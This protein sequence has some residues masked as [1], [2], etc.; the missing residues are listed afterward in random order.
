[1]KVTS[2]KVLRRSTFL[3]AFVPARFTPC[4]PPLFP[5]VLSYHIVRYARYSEAALQVEV[6]TLNG[7]LPCAHSAATMLA[8]SRLS[9][10]LPLIITAE[11]RRPVARSNMIITRVRSP[12]HV[13]FHDFV[14]LDHWRI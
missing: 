9:A 7:L 5:C 11:R 14:I 12:D 3:A 2:L 6:A 1:M 13:Q 10:C 8:V 4:P